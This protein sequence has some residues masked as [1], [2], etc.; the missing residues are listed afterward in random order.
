M[1]GRTFPLWSA[2]AMLVAGCAADQPAMTAPSAAP[3]FSRAGGVA[4]VS[5]M[6][7]NLYPGAN[8]DA[9]IAALVSPDPDDDLPALGFALN[10]LIET[11]FPTRAAAIADRIAR[12]RPHAVALQEVFAFDIDINFGTPVRILLPFLDVLQAELDARGLEYVVAAQ[13]LNFTLT[14]FPGITL[15][16]L[17]VLLVD[18]SRVTVEN[19]ANG[20]FTANLPPL[21]PLQIRRGWVYAE[22]RIEDRPYVLVG[23]HPESGHT[24]GLPELRAAQIGELLGLV[25]AAGPVLLM[26]DLNDFPDSPMYQLI[27]AAGFTDVWAA[28][29]PGADGSTCCHADDLSDPVARFDQRIDYIFARGFGAPPVGV[30]G[31]IRLFGAVPADRFPGPVHPLWPSDHAALLGRMLLPAAVLAGDT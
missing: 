7:Q 8:L 5:V 19:A 27:V 21:G 18:E 16:D 31:S 13:N 23:A 25:P 30:Q 1:S 11:D 4:V 10:T 15:S 29:R 14:P 17:D 2:A 28:L 3:A 9:V 20:T 26:G 24:P 22:V 6:T 12:E